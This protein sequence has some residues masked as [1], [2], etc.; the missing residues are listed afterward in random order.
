MLVEA[1]NCQVGWGR[2]FKLCAGPTL[3]STGHCAT[4]PGRLLASPATLIVSPNRE[5]CSRPGF[6]MVASG[7][8]SP[9]LEGACA[10]PSCF[11]KLELLSCVFSRNEF[12][13][14][15]HDA[16]AQGLVRWLSCFRNLSR[17][18][19]SCWSFPQPPNSA[20]QHRVAVPD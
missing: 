14:P 17:I 20:R 12:L 2:I 3:A 1:S 11:A 5:P 8:T 18:W 19:S 4:G 13:S 16:S 6:V 15:V 9:I 7:Q 10:V